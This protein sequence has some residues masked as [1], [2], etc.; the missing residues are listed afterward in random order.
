MKTQK[1]KGKGKM[2]EYKKKE[3]KRTIRKRKIQEKPK[4]KLLKPVKTRN[5]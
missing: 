5:H 3:N 4:E 1:R 2:K